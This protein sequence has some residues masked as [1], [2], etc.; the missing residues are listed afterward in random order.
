MDNAGWSVALK[1][2]HQ[3]RTSTTRGIRLP[4]PS[5]LSVDG[6]RSLVRLHVPAASVAANMQTDG[7][8]FEAWAL[9]LRHW[10]G[11]QA[12]ELS[13]EAPPAGSE[14]HYQRL[15]YRAAR[16]AALFPWFRLATADAL[17]DLR[18]RPD[19]PLLLNLRKTVAQ[20]EAVRAEAALE[21]RLSSDAAL[22]QR[23]GLVKLGTQVLVGLFDGDVAEACR[24]FPGGASAID[25][26]GVDEQRRLWA[27]ELKSAGNIKAGM[28]SELFFYGC[29]LQ[30]VLR[31]IIK[32][33]AGRSADTGGIQPADILSCD[34]IEARF[35]APAFHP[36]LDGGGVLALLNDAL[37][38]TDVPM[39]FGMIRL[40]G[41]GLEQPF[42]F[43]DLP[44]A[45]G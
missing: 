28:I 38:G 12:V 9:G 23:C 13:W 20:A 36:L 27:F 6:D 39:R 19:R 35:I 37:A 22:R 44:V 29:V 31:G 3:A 14:T 5:T 26:V 17:A 32:F 25:M 30:D 33:P 8:A 34:R 4:S 10:C 42:S 18:V 21:R 24:V 43:H 45:G 2:A 40:D 1:D 11:V 15:L 7:V 41:D 16:L